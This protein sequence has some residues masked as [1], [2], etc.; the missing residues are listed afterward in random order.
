MTI[1]VLAVLIIGGILYFG[2]R[3]PSVTMPSTVSSTPAAP[4]TS[5]ISTLPFDTTGWQS[6]QNSQYSIGLKYPNDWSLTFSSSTGVANI[7]LSK[8]DYI[9]T[10]EINNV[11]AN[12]SGQNIIPPSSIGLNIGGHKAWRT[13]NPIAD[14]YGGALYFNFIF[15]PASN[16]IINNRMSYTMDYRLSGTINA[17]N[18]DHSIINQMDDIVQTIVFTQK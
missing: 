7:I 12:Q 1:V 8:G 18:Y 10:I 17:S 15:A 11:I 5:A 13:A 14:G 9:L 2:A 16:W 3:G 6:Y 4:T